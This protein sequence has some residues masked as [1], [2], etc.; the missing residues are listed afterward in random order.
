VLDTEIESRFDHGR[1]V[2]LAAGDDGPSVGIQR[3]PEAKAT[4]NRVHVDVEV[5]ALEQMTRWVRCLSP[6]Y[7]W[8]DDL[9]A[10]TARSSSGASG[11]VLR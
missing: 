3:V 9:P 2:L 1:F 10:R 7:G 4:K 8:E 5:D 11:G 6:R